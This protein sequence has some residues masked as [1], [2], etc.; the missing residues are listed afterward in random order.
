MEGG[1]G[2]AQRRFYPKQPQQYAKVRSGL[3]VESLP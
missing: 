3:V 1:I 2:R